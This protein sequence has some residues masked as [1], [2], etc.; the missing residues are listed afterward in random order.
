MTPEEKLREVKHRFMAL[1]NGIV[2]DIYRRAGIT[3]YDV[4]FGLNLPQIAETAREF[5]PDDR[6]AQL[7][8]ADT[9]VRESRLLAIRLWPKDDA[10]SLLPQAQT[11][12]EADY[13]RLRMRQ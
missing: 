11:K 9:K 2:G 12:E 4:I 6:L 7:L 8:W 3:C 5:G 1:R 10:A 13:I